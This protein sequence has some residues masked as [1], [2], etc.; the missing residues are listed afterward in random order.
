MPQ[1]QAARDYANTLTE[2]TKVRH[3]PDMYLADTDSGFYSAQFRKRLI[4]EF[5]PDWHTNKGAGTRIRGLYALG[6]KY[7]VDELAEQMD[8]TGLDIGPLLEEI[9]AG[10]A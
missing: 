9:R 1:E 10:L 2:A 6:A 3:L 8:Y 5:G 7:T 4:Q